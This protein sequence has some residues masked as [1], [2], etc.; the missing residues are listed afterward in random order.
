MGCVRSKEQE[1]I[2]KAMG[3]DDFLQNA[4]SA[5]YVKDPTSGN[6]AVSR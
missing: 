2:N 5:H 3:N 1:P 4:Q 6:K